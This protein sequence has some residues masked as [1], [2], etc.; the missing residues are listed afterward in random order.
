M[1][2][3][4]VIAPIGRLGLDRL[5][6]VVADRDDLRIPAEAR[7]CLEMLAA[8]LDVV[9]VQILENDRLVRASARQTEVGRRLM[10][11]PGVGPLLSSAF[12]A[13]IGD[14]KMFKSGWDI[15]AWIRLVPR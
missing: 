13:S 15:A 10:E 6:A 8:Q 5:L 12:V 4:G 7:I 14:A 9:K 3:F 2:E 1:S 11:I